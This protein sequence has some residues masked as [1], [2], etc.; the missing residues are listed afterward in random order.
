MKALLLSLQFYLDQLLSLINLISIHL[1]QGIV[2]LYLVS[3]RYKI[4]N[5]FDRKILLLN[6]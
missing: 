4:A 3:L 5:I 2:S 1:D 6:E